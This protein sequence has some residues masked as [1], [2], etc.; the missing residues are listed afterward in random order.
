MGVGVGVGVG[1]GE[2][3]GVAVGIGVAVGVGVGTGI[4]GGAVEGVVT[5][6]GVSVGV[7]VG[8]GVGAGWRT[9][10][11]QSAS[12]DPLADNAPS[13]LY[14]HHSIEVVSFRS[15][16]NGS[17]RRSQESVT[18]RCHDNSE[19]ICSDPPHSPNAR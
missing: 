16:E 3:V 18:C 1:T 17:F 12:M 2:G 15:G 13:V 11:A 19:R 9:C 10:T 6:V 14:N 5:G 7:G 8:V 4:G